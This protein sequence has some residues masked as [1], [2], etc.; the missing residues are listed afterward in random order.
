MHDQWSASKSRPFSLTV[1]PALRGEKG[2]VPVCVRTEPR[3]ANGGVAVPTQSRPPSPATNPELTP[4]QPSPNDL[5]Q[6]QPPPPHGRPSIPR[7]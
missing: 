6:H 3:H 5:E 4:E 1:P 2:Q 7:K